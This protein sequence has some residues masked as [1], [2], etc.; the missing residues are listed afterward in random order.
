MYKNHNEVDF[1]SDSVFI[2]EN[3]VNIT[4]CRTKHLLNFNGSRKFDGLSGSTGV[5]GHDPELVLGALR[6]VGEG[7][8]AHLGG[9]G[10][11]QGPFHLVHL[12]HL[13]QVSRDDGA[14]LISRRQPGQRH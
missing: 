6:H 2:L 3:K 13:D 9:C 10:I 8:L 14:T 4:V 7:V 11:A 12:L 1:I 5:A